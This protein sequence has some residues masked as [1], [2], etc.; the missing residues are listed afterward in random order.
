MTVPDFDRLRIDARIADDVIAGATD[1]APVSGLTHTFYR[2]PA[3]FSP[4]FARSIIKAFSNEGDLIFDPFMGGG[5][6]LVEAS[7]LGRRAIGSDI[8]SLAAFV[9]EVKTT[10]LTPEDISEIEE[11]SKQVPDALNI[12]RFS[13]QLKEKWAEA[14]YQR[15]LDNPRTWR[16]RKLIE[17]A[18]LEVSHLRD[19]KHQRFARCVVLRTSQWALDGRKKVPSV[20]QFRERLIKNL[21]E[22]LSSASEFRDRVEAFAPGGLKNTFDVKCVQQSA[23]GIE[24]HPLFCEMQAPKIVLTS[25]PYPGIHV[26]YHRWQVDGRRETPAPF[27]IADRLDGAGS[28]YYTMGD[29]KNPAQNKYFKNVGDCFQSL[30]S[31][32]DEETLVIQ[33]VAFSDVDRQ[34]P[35]YIDTMECA[36]Y[37]ELL[38]PQLA[39]AKDGRLW[40]RVPNRKWHANQKGD[41]PGSKEVVLIHRLSKQNDHLIQAMR[42]DQNSPQQNHRRI[43]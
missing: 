11:W 40:R 8:S 42:P 32:L 9:S 43:Q 4:Q 29:R 13:A 35:R 10:I 20:S 5:T 38:V 30:S 27:W 33:M 17:L 16:I 2:Y 37:R 25:P 1:T 26:L 12:H 31:L 34:L 18:L 7:A 39:T 28:S 3:R 19:P 6:T 41:T 24:T 14:G 15:N 23:I 21:V 36:G 22:M